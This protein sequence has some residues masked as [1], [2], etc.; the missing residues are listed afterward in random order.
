MK[1]GVAFN[2]LQI[3]SVCSV[4]PFPYA[5]CRAD[6]VSLWYLELITGSGEVVPEIKP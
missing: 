4:V 3:I 2:P 6:P 1:D 5:V